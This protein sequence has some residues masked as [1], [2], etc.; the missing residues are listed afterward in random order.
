MPVSYLEI[1]TGHIFPERV[2][3]TLMLKG[4][5]VQGTEAGWGLR[6]PRINNCGVMNENKI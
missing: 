1:F 2:W 3:N 4:Q 6:D 5:A